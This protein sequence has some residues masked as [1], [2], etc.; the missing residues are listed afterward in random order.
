MS[1]TTAGELNVL[2]PSMSVHDCT[3]AG[4][5]LNVESDIVKP[6]TLGGVFRFSNPAPGRQR[7]R[8]GLHRE[9][10][11]VVV[12]GYFEVLASNGPRSTPQIYRR[13][14]PRRLIP[15]PVRPVLPPAKIR[16]SLFLDFSLSS[17]EVKIDRYLNK[18]RI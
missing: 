7:E 17:R 15:I 4:F 14:I 8:P 2:Q 5:S 6:Q 12:S 9:W 10:R 3:V 16:C 11:V 13:S 1:A 18:Q